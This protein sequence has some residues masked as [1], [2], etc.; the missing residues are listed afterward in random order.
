MFTGFIA[1][2]PAAI[3]RATPALGASPRFIVTAVAGC[4]LHPVGRRETPRVA[5]PSGFIHN[6][7]AP[8]G[9]AAVDD[10]IILFNFKRK[11]SGYAAFRDYYIVQPIS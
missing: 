4:V 11:M 2:G 10:L 5:V 3:H 7:T 1:F 9:A 8:E 6:A